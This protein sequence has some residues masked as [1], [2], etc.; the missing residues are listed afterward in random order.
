MLRG[1]CEILDRMDGMTSLPMWLLSTDLTEKQEPAIW[2]S[3]GELVRQRESNC[4]ALKKH[5]LR[6]AGGTA[7]RPDWLRQRARRMGGCGREV[8]EGCAA[9]SRQGAATGEWCV[10]CGHDLTCVFIGSRGSHMD[11]GRKGG[12]GAGGVD[13]AR[14]V[15]RLLHK[16]R[17]EMLRQTEP[18]F[19]R[20]RVYLSKNQ[21]ESGSPNRKWLEA[22]HPKGAR[23]KTYIH[24]VWKQRKSFDWLQ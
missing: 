19:K 17:W 16:P 1:R 4:K 20:L 5:Q 24:K 12:Q 8:T 7:R 2:I 21:S 10:K 23:V 14:P 6:H 22:H 11:T 13:M 9:H 3:G 15:T 18:I